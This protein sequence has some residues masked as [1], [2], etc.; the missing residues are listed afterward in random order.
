MDA[1]VEE[2]LKG[3]SPAEK[4][5][6]LTQYFYFRLP[7]GAEA[8]PALGLDVAQQP[9]A[10]EAALA[11]GEAGSL[12]FVTDPAEIN[13]LQRLALEGGDI[14]LL[15]GF[16]V[17][18]GL[19]TIFPVPIAMAASWDPATIER[20]QAVAAREARAVGI[21]WA[22]AP[23][24]DIARDPRWG[25]IVEGA[26]ED[27]FLGAAVAA[28][29]VRGFQGEG[30][31]IAGP[32]HFGGYGAALGGRDYDEANLSDYE[33]R[34][35]YFPPFK[36]AVEAGAGNIMTAY[37]DLNGTPASASHWLFTEVLR[38]TWGFD[39]FV[40]SDANAVRNLVTHGF[41]RDL[42]EAG[43]RAVTAGVGAR[44]CCCATRATCFR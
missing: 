8:E 28:A 27:P 36:A 32:K 26:G 25:R 44:P 22:F 34:N 43:A 29:Q 13:R 2:L 17:I 4:A 1:R 16:D 3:M 39:G 6:Q 9:R 42:P 20:G 10:V 38:D 12:L 5:G 15:F 41:A 23:M 11:A 18:H 40:V 19:R 35:V 24:V 7:A 21:H 31:V 37:M 30:G 14:P 33:L